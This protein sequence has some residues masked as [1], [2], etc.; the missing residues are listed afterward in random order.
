VIL[1]QLKASLFLSKTL[2]IFFLKDQPFDVV[3]KFKELD[4]ICPICFGP[5]IQ[6]P[7]CFPARQIELKNNLEIFEC[8]NAPWKTRHYLEKT[9]YDW[10]WQYEYTIGEENEVFYID[11]GTGTGLVTPEATSDI[12]LPKLLKAVNETQ[13]KLEII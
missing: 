13:R 8:N 6:L 2:N 3:V 5:L 1:P 11:M 4:R 9:W 12:V 7:Y 10:G